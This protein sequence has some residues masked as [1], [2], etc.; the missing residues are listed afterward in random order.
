MMFFVVFCTD[1]A[2]FEDVRARARPEHR[3]H[4]RNPG[5]HPV[6]VRIGGPTHRADGA[7]NGTMLVVEAE[8]ESHVRA[9][10]AD[11]PY[12]RAELFDNV[13]VRPW[14]WGIGSPEQSS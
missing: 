5:H 13:D 8:K 4:L 12:I 7:M 11:D 6:Q 9:F 3:Q 1:K 14:T 2:G 10:L